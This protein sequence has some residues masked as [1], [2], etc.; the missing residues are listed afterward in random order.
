MNRTGFIWL[1]VVL[2]GGGV[3]LLALGLVIAALEVRNR[4][5]AAQNACLEAAL[6]LV[7]AT[8]AGDAWAVEAAR[9]TLAAAGAELKALRSLQTGKSGRGGG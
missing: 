6:A 4:I 7:K 5:I 2:F 3:A 1:V 9:A 8:Q